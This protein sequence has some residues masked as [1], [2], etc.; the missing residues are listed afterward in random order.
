MK[1]MHTLIEKIHN[2]TLSDIERSGNML[3]L[4]LKNNADE[5]ELQ[6][7]CPCRI[8]QNNSVLLA[9]GDMYEP[10]STFA[11]EYDDFDWEVVGATLF[12]EK[13]EALKNKYVVE[14]VELSMFN[15]LKIQFSD[16]ILLTTFSNESEEEEQWRLFHR[17]Y[18]DEKQLVVSPSLMEED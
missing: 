11:G 12:D 10:T 2:C 16:G 6:V 13:K 17:F 3:W 5:Y 14:S 8:T 15:D 18:R 7:C 9:K 1:L 4:V